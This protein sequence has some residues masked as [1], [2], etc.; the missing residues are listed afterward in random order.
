MQDALFSMEGS[1]FASDV[2]W[3]AIADGSLSPKIIAAAQVF[4]DALAPNGFVGR[5]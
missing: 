4:Y 1:W 2:P 5:H 3:R